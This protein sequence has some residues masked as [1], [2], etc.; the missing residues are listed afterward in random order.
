[1]PGHPLDERA[2]LP[3]VGAVVVAV[4]LWIGLPAELEDAEVP[5]RRVGGQDF[6]RDELSRP[7]AP[8]EGRP[9]L[10]VE[11]VSG[12]PIPEEPPTAV[13]EG[14]QQPGDG[15]AAEL[16]GH[17]DAEGGAVQAVE[18]AAGPAMAEPNPVLGLSLV[19]QLEGRV[20]ELGHEQ[21]ALLLG[22]AEQQW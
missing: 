11:Q 19:L 6:H 10:I 18:P 12:L 8:R 17:L 22:R 1:Q 4:G 21:G 14:P 3:K 5:D 13:A 9:A 16:P 2:Q 7:S 15:G 20:L